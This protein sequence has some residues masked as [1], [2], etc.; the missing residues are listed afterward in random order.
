MSALPF[1]GVVFYLRR[2][3][4]VERGVAQGDQLLALGQFDRLGKWTVP[5]HG[6]DHIVRAT[7]K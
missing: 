1:F 5:R 6:L 3:G 2:F 4:D 7:K